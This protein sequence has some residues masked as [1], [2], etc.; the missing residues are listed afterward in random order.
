MYICLKIDEYG[1]RTVFYLNVQKVTIYSMFFESAND[2]QRENF[3]VLKLN[4]T[5]F[6]ISS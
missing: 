6:F 4:Y 2:G 5:Y 1:F 3:F